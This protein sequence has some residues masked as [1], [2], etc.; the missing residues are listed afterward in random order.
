M[1]FGSLLDYFK[2]TSIICPLSI[3]HSVLNISENS[4]K[5]LHRAMKDLFETNKTDEFFTSQRLKRQIR[6]VYYFK[7]L[8]YQAQ[9]K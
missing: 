2:S 1:C 7:G 5:C 9:C 3:N 4:E 8:L 6:K